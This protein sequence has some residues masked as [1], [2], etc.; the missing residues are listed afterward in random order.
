MKELKK[1]LKIAS[2][3]IFIVGSLSIGDYVFGIELSGGQYLLGVWL[4]FGLAAIYDKLSKTPHLNVLVI[5][6]V[7]QKGMELDWHEF[8]KRMDFPIVP[9]GGDYIC[10]LG[11]SFG[12]VSSVSLHAADVEFGDVT[13]ARVSCSR[14]V[15]NA[16]ELQEVI[17]DFV[18]RGWSDRHIF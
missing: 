10:E 11:E 14:E 16:D 15:G 4:V 18:E 12:Q 2:P 9:R 17:E 6:R 7:Q 8:T 5:Y 13:D 3:A 1:Y